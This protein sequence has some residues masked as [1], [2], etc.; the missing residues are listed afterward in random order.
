MN[1][2]VQVFGLNGGNGGG[3]Q[4]GTPLGQILYMELN[5][6]QDI[7]VISPFV[8]LDFVEVSNTID[9]ATV[10]SN[11]PLDGQTYKGVVTLP[12]GKY[13]SSFKIN[14]Q[15]GTNSQKIAVVNI[16]RYAPSVVY[17]PQSA[18]Y[19]LARSNGQF[20][21]IQ[22]ADA[23]YTFFELTEAQSFGIITARTFNAGPLNTIPDQSFWKIEK[24]AEADQPIVIDPLVSSWAT[25]NSVNDQNEIDQLNTMYTGINTIVS[26]HGGSFLKFNSVSPTSYSAAQSDLIN[27]TGNTNNLEVG[28]G[29]TYSSDG[30]QF[31]GSNN[32]WDQGAWANG[33]PLDQIL[34]LHARPFDMTIPGVNGSQNGPQFRASN[35]NAFYNG[36]SNASTNWSR[37]GIYGYYNTGI[38]FNLWV[39]GVKVAADVSNPISSSLGTSDN[40]LI[41]ARNNTSGTAPVNFM[42]E[43]LSTFIA[44]NDG[45]TRFSDAD[46]VSM[47]DLIQNYNDNV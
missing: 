38:D 46:I 30:V 10:D 20:S 29:I 15:N 47:F 7:N 8:D 17:Y 22:C 16:S 24:I 31:N 19:G 25:S 42:D 21:T 11:F 9:G 43:S 44:I 45:G 18:V 2:L 41:G 6:S 12:P 35:T 4:E 28:T 23:N 14:V 27:I 26:N 40:M 5:S 36:I 33:V 32:A 3:G 13:K 37:A 34:I 39:D 1:K